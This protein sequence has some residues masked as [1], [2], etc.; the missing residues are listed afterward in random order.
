[1][2]ETTFETIPQRQAREEAEATERRHAEENARRQQLASAQAAAAW[3]ATEAAREKQRALDAESEA[4]SKAKRLLS[5]LEAARGQAAGLR[6]ELAADNELAPLRDELA[7]LTAA[8]ARRPFAATLQ[9]PRDVDRLA[10]LR[11]LIELAPARKAHK[12]A[13]LATVEQE[14]KRLEAEFAATQTLFQ[15]A[16][17]AAAKFFKRGDGGAA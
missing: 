2:S 6:G 12:A 9:D 8:I 15:K 16:Q 10:R 13:E 3:K 14:I 17:A 5:D 11:L 1:M 7:D 4:A